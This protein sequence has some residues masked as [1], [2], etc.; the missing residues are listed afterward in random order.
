MSILTQNEAAVNALTA[1]VDPAILTIKAFDKKGEWAI[2]VVF[3]DGIKAT[4]PSTAEEVNATESRLCDLGW[5]VDPSL[6]SRGFNAKP[7]VDDCGM[8]FASSAG[9]WPDDY[10][11]EP[12]L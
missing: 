10:G 2:E 11:L 3:E 1:P 9:M 8:I 4:R 5:Q 7:P 12:A 6:F